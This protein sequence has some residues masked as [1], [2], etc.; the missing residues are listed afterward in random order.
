MAICPV[1]FKYFKT[2]KGI[3]YNIMH[4]IYKNFNFLIYPSNLVGMLSSPP[5]THTSFSS[6]GAILNEFDHNF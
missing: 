6:F 1:Y 2:I 3:N 5:L 4:K